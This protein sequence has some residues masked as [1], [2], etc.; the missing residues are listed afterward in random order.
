MQTTKNLVV[1]NKRELFAMQNHIPGEVA[2]CI[3]TKE[4]FIWDEYKG[5][6][7]MDIEN[8]GLE[9]NLYDLNKNIV[10][11]L[12]PLTIDEINLKTDLFE[13]YSNKVENTYHMLLCRDFNYYTIFAFSAMPEFPSFAEAVIT[14]ITEIG[15]VYSI[16]LNEDN[17]FEIWIKPNGEENPYAFYLFPYDAGVIYY[18]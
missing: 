2:Y 18:G 14:I 6:I 1:Q 8:K 9:L 7:L 15:E 10:S 5:W 16:E 4:V 3:E 13:S 11:Q 17:A 12:D